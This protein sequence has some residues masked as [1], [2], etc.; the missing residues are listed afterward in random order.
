MVTIQVS[1]DGTTCDVFIPGQFSIMFTSESIVTAI[2]FCESQGLEWKLTY[3][4][5]H[6]RKSNRSSNAT[7]RI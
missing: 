3:A 5:S 1:L 6:E 7:R 2:E 4:T